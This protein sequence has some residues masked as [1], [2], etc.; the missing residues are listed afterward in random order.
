MPANVITGPAGM[1]VSLVAAR[2]AAR[3]NGSA[4]DDEI[5]INVGAATTEAEHHTGLVFIDRTYR[6]TL[7]RFDGDIEMPTSPVSAV[8]NFTYVDENGDLQE[9]D[10]AD[11]VLDDKRRP[12]FIIP[13]FEKAF[14]ATRAQANAINI[15]VVC[16][17]GPTDATVPDAAKGYILAR[18]REMYAPP[19]TPTSPFLTAGLNALKVY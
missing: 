17:H 3:V 6:I 2:T 5:K 11:Y 13:A 10:P 9:L 18:L 1:A 15:D 8:L 7:D 4:L 14:P 19:G 16:G 12:G